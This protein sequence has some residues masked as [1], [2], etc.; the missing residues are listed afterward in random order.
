VNVNI[1]LVSGHQT[2][3]GVEDIN[4]TNAPFWIERS[5]YA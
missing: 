3:R 2:A 4:M 1:E 5:L